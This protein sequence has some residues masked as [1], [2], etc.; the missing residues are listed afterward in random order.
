MITRNGDRLGDEVT[1][2]IDHEETAVASKSPTRFILPGV[3]VA[4]GAAAAL[5]FSDGGIEQ[6]DCVSIQ[7]RGGSAGGR[8]ESY[9]IEETSCG[10]GADVVVSTVADI[11]NC[12]E[13]TEGYPIEG[14]D[15]CVR[16]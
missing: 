6:G 2:D 14:D 4:G 1:A 5:L 10:G 8:L 9:S 12:P 3:I 16:T 11:D 13:G 15:L 7:S